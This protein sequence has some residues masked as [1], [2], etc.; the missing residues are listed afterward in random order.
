MTWHLSWT[1]TSA[2]QFDVELILQFL[3]DL[4]DKFLYFFEV[5]CFFLRFKGDGE[6]HALLA[7]RNLAALVNIELRG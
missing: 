1:K 4:L 2:S 3:A 5:K 6:R 7:F